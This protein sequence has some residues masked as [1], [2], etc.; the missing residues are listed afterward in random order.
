MWMYT[1]VGSRRCGDGGIKQMG[2]KN[3]GMMDFKDMGIF[4]GPGI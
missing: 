1:S 2:M 3:I 4:S